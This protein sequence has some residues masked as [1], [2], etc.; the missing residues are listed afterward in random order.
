MSRSD[1][2]FD[3][4][5]RHLGAAYYQ[6]IHGDGTASDVARALVS[7]EAADGRERDSRGQA[8]RPH[9]GRWRVRDV[10]TT[11]VVT[12]PAQMPYSRWPGS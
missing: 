9:S 7:A 4:M 10:M 11:D 6:T 2:H 12:V 5:L 3:A 1:V 8:R